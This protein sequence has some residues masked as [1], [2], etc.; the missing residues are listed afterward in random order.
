M[1]LLRT[2]S[3]IS[4]AFGSVISFEHVQGV[5]NAHADAI[6]CN[7][8]AS[9]FSQVLGLS[10]QPSPIPEQLWTLLVL[11]QVRW[12]MLFHHSPNDLANLPEYVMSLDKDVS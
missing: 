4:A 9:L 10:S 8:V 1:H 12:R 6:S 2:L 11:E 7:H 3:F 5:D